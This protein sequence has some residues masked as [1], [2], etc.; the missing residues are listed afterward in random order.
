[1]PEAAQLALNVDYAPGPVL[2]GEAH[3]QLDEFAAERWPSRRS[4]LVPLSRYHAPVPA[5]QCAGRD[6][7][8]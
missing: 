5:Q 4:R 2:G 3:D 1:M 8:V 6:D 7:P